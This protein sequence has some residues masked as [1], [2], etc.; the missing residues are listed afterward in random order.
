MTVVFR[1]H[2]RARRG[3]SGSRQRQVTHG[4]TVL[5]VVEIDKLQ[6]R[7]PKSSGPMAVVISAFGVPSIST[8]P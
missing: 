8:R 5:E 3:G 1:K 4:Y 7:S 6:R 2:P